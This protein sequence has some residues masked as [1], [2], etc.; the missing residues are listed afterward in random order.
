VDRADEMTRIRPIPGFDRR[1]RP[2]HTRWAFLSSC[3]W[4]WRYPAVFASAVAI[5]FL[6]TWLD[7]P[8]DVLHRSVFNFVLVCLVVFWFATGSKPAARGACNIL[9]LRGFDQE[10]RRNLYQRVLPILGCY[11][12][13]LA[14]RDPKE[15]PKDDV[16][17]LLNS[18]FLSDLDE[19]EVVVAEWKDKVLEL[20]LQC[21]LAVIDVTRLTKAVTWE[22]TAALR[23]LPAE[24]VLL[25]S[26]FSRP[27]YQGIVDA[28]VV[29]ASMCRNEEPKVDFAV[30]FTWRT[31]P[32]KFWKAWP[33]KFERQIAVCM[34]KIRPC[35][36]EVSCPIEG[37]CRWAGNGRAQ[38]WLANRHPAP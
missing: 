36:H 33:L 28:M 4:T 34:K 20:L 21:D 12:R 7:F 10:R 16:I 5:H 2:P 15:R 22:L 8:S 32:F 25:I 17:G 38:C 1:L 3:M 19:H 14:L 13:L 9:V 26:E 35:T 23:C 11:G 27:L 30:Y 31:W 37:S 6:L 18:K 24:R 29:A